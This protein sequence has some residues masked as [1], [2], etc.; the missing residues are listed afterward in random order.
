[1]LEVVH[2][3]FRLCRKNPHGEPI[4]RQAHGEGG[5]CRP[6]GKL[7]MSG[8]KLEQGLSKVP[9]QS[10]LNL[11]RLIPNPWQYAACDAEK[12]FVTWQ[13]VDYITGQIVGKFCNGGT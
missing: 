2:E 5:M 6:F 1:M 11:G 7:R 13:M 4:L 9:G 12:G 3:V 8:D 10:W